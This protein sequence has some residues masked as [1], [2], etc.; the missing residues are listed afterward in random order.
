M[1]LKRKDELI[2]GGIAFLM[3]L[4]ILSTVTIS[5]GVASQDEFLTVVGA[6]GEMASVTGSVFALVICGRAR[7]RASSRD[8][9]TRGT[10]GYG[11]GR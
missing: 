9:S 3:V 4:A 1:R 6:V 10:S 8:G 5:I 11:L 2:A 7:T